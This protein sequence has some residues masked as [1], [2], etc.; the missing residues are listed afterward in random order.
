MARM[1]LIITLAQY[2]PKKQITHKLNE[3]EHQL[4]FYQ[5]RSAAGIRRKTV[6]AMSALWGVLT[7][8]SLG[9]HPGRIKSA[10]SL[11]G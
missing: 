2:V 4:T 3:N 6:G 7:F 1:S 5:R 11:I 9:V 8:T 10:S